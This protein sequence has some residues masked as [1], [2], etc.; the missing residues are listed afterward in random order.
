MFNYSLT[1]SAAVLESIEFKKPLP[2]LSAL[3]V[4]TRIL[5]GTT[6]C[7]SGIAGEKKVCQI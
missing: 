2:P 5:E 1:G 7:V 3:P 6:I 4:C